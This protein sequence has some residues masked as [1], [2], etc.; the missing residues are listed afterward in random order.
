MGNMIIFVRNKLQ[1]VNIKHL[2]HVRK[3]AIA[4]ANISLGC[5]IF[6]VLSVTGSLIYGVYETQRVPHFMADVFLV[7]PLLPLITTMMSSVGGAYNYLIQ[8]GVNVERIKDIVEGQQENSHMIDKSEFDTSDSAYEDSYLSVRD[9]FF[10]DGDVHILSHINITIKRGETVAFV[11][12]VGSGKSTLLHMIIGLYPMHSGILTLKN[13]DA[14]RCSIYG[15][16]SQFS[17]VAQNSYVFSDSIFEN[18]AIGLSSEYRSTLSLEQLRELVESAAMKAGIHDYISEL[19]AGYDT[20]I[21][22]GEKVLSGGERKRIMLARAFIRNADI[23]VL[24][25]PTAS[26]DIENELNIMESLKK[27]GK[28]KTILLTAHKLQTI[29]AVDKIYVMDA[30]RIIEEG[31]HEELMKR[32]GAYYNLW[33]AQA[34]SEDSQNSTT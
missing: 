1:Q 29:Q 25:E 5:E 26:L 30:G 24:D 7:L 19:P 3:M 4:N 31:N 20:I 21:G 15:W 18:I 11:G 27:Y 9:G 17:F 23:L 32:K 22:E 10:M 13:V 33:K 28:E 14:S 34:M 6:A 8:V 2:K 12:K 16:R